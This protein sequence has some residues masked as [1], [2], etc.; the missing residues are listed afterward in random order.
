MSIKMNLL[1]GVAFWALG[2]VAAESGAF[3]GF[4]GQ[5]R[6]VSLLTRDSVV[7]IETVKKDNT[8]GITGDPSWGEVGT[9]FLID[10]EDGIILTSAQTLQDAWKIRILFS[11][12]VSR[13][14]VV[15][16]TDVPTDIGVVKLLHPRP[17]IPALVIASA[18]D[19]RV[20][21]P[22][23]SMGADPAGEM[24]YSMGIISAKPLYGDAAEG[25]LSTFLQYDASLN[26]GMQGGPLLSLRGDVV[27]MA[28]FAAMARSEMFLNFAVPASLLRQVSDGIV[29]RGYYLHLVWGINPVEPSEAI[30]MSLG[31]EEGGVYLPGVSQGDSADETGLKGG[32]FILAVDDN[33]SNSTDEFW[34]QVA[35]WTLQT[36][37]ELLAHELTIWRDGQKE[38][39]SF[40]PVRRV[41]E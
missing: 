7:I 41:V 25:D 31:R 15:V 36:D 18:S 21:E 2:V 17:T 32:D 30:R 16:G 1:V 8:P 10:S 34:R 38:T 5:L 33:T 14:G 6:G 11:D 12:G 40:V 9:G 19:S 4:D 24:S 27:G 39:I 23:L 37:E 28:T 29:E 3:R 22:I 26:G 20:G 35:G 13:E